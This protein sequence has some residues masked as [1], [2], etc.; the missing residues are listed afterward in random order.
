MFEENANKANDFEKQQMLNKFSV[1]A[2]LLVVI[3]SVTINSVTALLVSFLQGC[4][5]DC[6][7]KLVE[8]KQQ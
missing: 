3:N 7:Y 4:S 2:L 1:G 8:M 5:V 6:A